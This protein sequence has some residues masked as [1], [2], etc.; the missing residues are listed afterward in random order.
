MRLNIKKM[1]EGPTI[2]CRQWQTIRPNK[3]WD[4]GDND[5][6]DG[7]NV[8]V[9]SQKIWRCIKAFDETRTSSKKKQGNDM[10]D[11]TDKNRCKTRKGARRG[12][13]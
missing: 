8:R 3:K 10:R 13:I 1:S 6:D 12:N 9:G 7:K 4:K 5:E 2:D 11:V